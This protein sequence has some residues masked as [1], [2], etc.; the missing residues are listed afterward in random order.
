MKCE[1]CGKEIQVGQ[2]LKYDGKTFCDHDCLGDWFIDQHEDEIEFDC[3]HS[4]PENDYIEAMEDREA[5]RRD[6]AH[7]W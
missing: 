4:T 3:W 2:Y 7:E 1:Y 5:V 6:L